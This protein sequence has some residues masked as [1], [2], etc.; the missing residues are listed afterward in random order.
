VTAGALVSFDIDGTLEMGDPPGIITL[1]M[2]RAAKRRGLLI[3]SC[4]DRPVSHQRQLWTRLAI[5][6]DFVVLK[7]R[8][9]EVRAQFP[10][11]AY[12]HV[13]DTEIDAHC[14]VAAGFEF[15]RADRVGHAE[16]GP[17]LFGR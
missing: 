15:L 3:G 10:A 14:A 9:A 17:R 16:W 11:P 6:P 4:S 5:I 12:Y 8:L 1:E 13:G 2:L 7:H